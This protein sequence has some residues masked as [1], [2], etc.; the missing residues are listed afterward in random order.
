[1]VTTNNRQLNT[2]NRSIATALFG[3]ISVQFNKPKYRKCC[4]K[5]SGY[6]FKDVNEEI[7]RKT[8]VDVEISNIKLCSQQ[9]KRHRNFVDDAKSFLSAVSDASTR[10]N[11]SSYI[12]NGFCRKYAN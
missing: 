7:S 2:I 3:T 10:V 11:Y 4:W 12:V 8:V 6:E 9:E 1:M 5:S